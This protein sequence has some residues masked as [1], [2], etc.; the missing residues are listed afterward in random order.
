MIEDE[1]FDADR[2]VEVAGLLSDPARHATVS[3]AARDLARPDAA[4]AVADLVLAVAR[5]APLPTEA[6][7]EAVARGSRP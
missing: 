2:L 7:I 1:Q 5:R 4:A 6:E 3:A